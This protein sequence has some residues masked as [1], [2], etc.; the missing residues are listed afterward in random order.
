MVS[1]SLHRAIS[2]QRERTWARLSPTPSFRLWML[3]RAGRGGPARRKAIRTFRLALL[4]CREGGAGTLMGGETLDTAHCSCL[5]LSWT[6]EAVEIASKVRTS[7]LA[8]LKV[9]IFKRAGLLG[10][11]TARESNQRLRRQA[12]QLARDRPPP[13][14]FPHSL[15]ATA[16]KLVSAL[17]PPG[18]LDSG[19]FYRSWKD[20]P[21]DE[22]LS[23]NA[24]K[25]RRR[26]ERAENS[27]K[28]FEVGERLVSKIA[29]RLR[30]DQ[31]SAREETTDEEELSRKPSQ[32]STSTIE[33]PAFR[34]ATPLSL[35]APMPANRLD[36]SFDFLSPPLPT[37]TPGFLFDSAASTLSSHSPAT[38]FAPPKPKLGPLFNDAEPSPFPFTPLHSLSEAAADEDDYFTVRRTTRRSPTSKPPPCDVSDLHALSPAITGILDTPPITSFPNPIAS[39]IPPSPRHPSSTP[40]RLRVT[41]GSPLDFASRTFERRA[42]AHAGLLIWIAVGSAKPTINGAGLDS[43]GGVFG[44]LLHLIGFLF[45]LVVHS[46]SLVLSTLITLRSIALFGHWTFLNLTG[47]TDLSLV[48]KEYLVLCRKEWDLV[49]EQ[50][51]VRLGVWSVAIGLLE[52]AAIQAMSKE[53][54][55]AEGPGRLKLLNGEDEEDF[56]GELAAA[57]PGRTRR[58]RSLRRRESIGFDRPGIGRRRTT[59]RW[60]EDDGEGDRLLV[61]GGGDLIVE[62]TILNDSFDPIA[63]L[64]PSPRTFVP[65]D[66]LD[67]LPPI[68]LGDAL[69]GFSFPPTPR[70]PASPFHS[71][72][73]PSSPPL[74]PVPDPRP[75]PSLL[76]TMKRHAR[77]ATASYGLHSY[78][79]DPVMPFTP[80][81]ATLPHRI[82]AHL[83]GVQGP[84]NV[85][86]VAIQKEYLSGP[87]EGELDE[88]YEPQIYLLRDDVNLEV[89]CVVR[90]TQSLADIKTD[91]EASFDEVELPSLVPG[92]EPETFLAHAGI[93]AAARRLLK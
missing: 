58:K 84:D 45:F 37:L 59:R 69:P 60:A 56:S 86:H 27:M 72:A 79:I 32:A 65:S 50:D 6:T 62:G 25:E 29:E 16:S 75:L 38:P 48:A 19:K 35:F 10:T 46:Y 61:T 71:F 28:G 82:F 9:L 76:K 7:S 92:E 42:R 49:C 8:L 13:P 85:L 88:S 77:L 22:G 52:M 33:A 36:N 11:R 63:H 93:L 83:G 70:T 55:I 73:T 24:K 80:S 4:D 54:W 47:R 87:A 67:D 41:L 17:G 3:H 23:G 12:R 5:R 78:L 40:T 31:E 30:R 57:S 51:G 15:L 66:D 39:H 90:G 34:A 64:S 21:N 91:L 26:L 1:P 14:V 68:D 89:V 43:V 81:G 74:R 53:R 2:L 44:A 18:G 20:D